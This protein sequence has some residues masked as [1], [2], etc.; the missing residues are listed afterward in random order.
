M[1]YTENARH[2]AGAVT[3]GEPDAHHNPRTFTLQATLDRA[4]RH[5]F[6]AEALGALLAL[7]L[8]WPRCFLLAT[9]GLMALPPEDREAVAATVLADLRAGQPIP[10]FM[11]L[12]DDARDWAG[13]AST[14]ER[15]AYLAATWNALAD[16]DRRAFMARVMA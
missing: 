14:A 5:E 8:D 4:W 11:D 13:W 7:R 1:A 15:R 10:P 6:T 12:R 9:G 16:H 3:A 2:G